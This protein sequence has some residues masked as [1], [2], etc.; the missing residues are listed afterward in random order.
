MAK[1][2]LMWDETLFRDPMVFEI[3]FVPDEFL[4][5][6]E[7]IADLAFQIQPGLRGGRPLNSLCRGPPGTGKTTTVR[8]LFEEIE[9]NTKKIVPVHINCQIDNTRFAIL[10]KIYKRLAG[11]LPQASG[12]SFKQVYDAVCRLLLKDDL[13]L[14]VCLDDA[15]YLL[16][17]NEINN[18]L[19][20]LLRA[21]EVY[22]TIRVSAIVIFSDMDINPETAFDARVASVFRPTEVFFSPYTAAEVEAILRMRV[23]QGFYPGVVS[24]EVLHLVVDQTMRA[25]DLRVGIDLLK[26]AGLLAERDARK[27][28]VP[29]DVSQAYEVSQRFH[30]TSLV[31][32][33]KDDEKIVLSVIGLMSK[34]GV[35]TSAGEVYSRV[36]ETMSLGYTRYS[37]II[38]KL[39]TI[40]IINLDYRAGRGR[41][42]VITLRFDPETVLA[43]VG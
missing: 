17:E 26:R 40:R 28:V 20:P 38:K 3:D 11:H 19:Y 36:R 31:R 22:E 33:L 34:D 23:V 39:D 1:R 15:N 30:L 24:D 10:A 12:T 6:E 35:E 37:E 32:S 9:G 21:H 25:G 41:T 16:Y 14:I 7:Q 42:R 5:R 8:K 2:L 43:E 29:D 27:L 4:F 13:V 18:V